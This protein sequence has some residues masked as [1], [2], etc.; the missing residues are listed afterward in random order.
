MPTTSRRS[1]GCKRYP[2]DTPAALSALRFFTPGG[3]ACAGGL[4]E[5]FGCRVV[6][7]GDAG[8]RLGPRGVIAIGL[9]AASLRWG[10]SGFSDNLGWVYAAQALHGVTVWGVVIG[11]PLYADRIMPARLRS[12][13]QSLLAMVGISLGSILSKFL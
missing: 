8:R 4:Q 9:A 6:I 5:G 1:W 13:G 3:G 12:T 11:I 7:A 2:V 10:I